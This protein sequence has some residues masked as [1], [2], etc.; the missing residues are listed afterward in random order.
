MYKFGERSSQQLATCHIDLVKIHELAITRTKVDY[1]I[2]QGGRTIQQQ[3]EYFNNKKSKINP[4]NYATPEDLAKVAKHIIVS[5]DTR[6][7]RSRATDVHVA[8][9]YKGRS[10]AWDTVHL[11]YVA[12]TLMSCA[13]ELYD[14][15]EITHLLR[16]GADWDSDGI[17]GLDH[18]LRDFPH[19]ELIKP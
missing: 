1:G 6:Y 13:Q 8:E 2:H 12:A 19:V 15:G 5:G 18:V 10:L 14:K 17:I 9:K 4:K 7:N 16:W 3:Q 11:S